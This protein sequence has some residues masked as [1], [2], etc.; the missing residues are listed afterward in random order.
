M[1]L[2]NGLVKMWAWLGGGLYLNLFPTS[3]SPRD[4]FSKDWYF[5]GIVYLSEVSESEAN[6]KGYICGVGG[7]YRGFEEGKI[8]EIDNREFFKLHKFVE[9][10]K[11]IRYRFQSSKYE[12]KNPTK[13]TY[14]IS[15]ETAFEPI[16]YTIIQWLPK[17]V[18]LKS[19]WSICRGCVPE[20]TEHDKI[21]YTSRFRKH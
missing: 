12:P 18:N 9:R 16:K 10:R 21:E 17:G 14:W 11:F 5:V 6:Q 4:K 20:G 1:K 7:E 3:K 2:K 15:G 13:Y 8:F 19:V